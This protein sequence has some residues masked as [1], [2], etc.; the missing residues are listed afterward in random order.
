[1]DKETRKKSLDYSLK[2]GVAW[3]VNSGLGNSYITPYA[4]A[5]NANEAQIGLL[6]S[7]PNLVANLAQI[8]TPKLMERMSRKRITTNCVLL[9]ALTWLPIAF[10]AFMFLFLG[11]NGVIAPMLVILFFTLLLTLGTFAAPAWSSWLGD[12]VPKGERGRFLG[13]RDAILSGAGIL[14]MLLGGL[15]LDLF[16]RSEVLF[17]FVALF[18]MAMAARLISWYFLRKQYEPKYTYKGEYYFTFSRFVRRMKDNNFGRFTV[19]VM[20]M[21]LVVNIAAP[22]FSVYMLQELKFSYFIFVAI[23]LSASFTHML[24]IPLWG[25]FSDKYG[26]LRPLRMCGLLVPLVPILWLFSTNPIYLIIVECFSG[27]IWAGFNLA[28]TN[29]IYDA[30]SKQRRGICFAYFGALNGIGIF[31]GA[32]LGGVFA[33]YFKVGFMSTLLFLFL[34]S[35]ILRL[36]VSAAMLHKIKEV[37]KVEPARP[38][39][40]FMGDVIRKRMPPRAH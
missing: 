24:G 30:V 29:F 21:M 37:R 33:T 25:K 7:V 16:R 19:Y 36:A 11:I 23:I 3:S 34:I 10:V 17:G 31:V 22:F 20:L 9:Q 2:D 27:F 6:T 40:Y 12:L 15:F 32:T 26:N 18:L 38:L 39:W 1:M 14:A 13:R 8:K 28:A 4:L 5:M 35:G